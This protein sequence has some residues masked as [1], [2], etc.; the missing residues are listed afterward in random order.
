MYIYIYI[1]I[2]ICAST[3]HVLHEQT[4]LM[5]QYLHP[6]EWF[7]LCSLSV[8]TF[9][10]VFVLVLVV[11]VVV[12]VLLLL[13]LLLLLSILLLLFSMLAVGEVSGE[14]FGEFFQRAT[15]MST[16]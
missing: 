8:F 9:T 5:T 1:Y 14:E 3:Y 10:F 12:V 4:H 16:C 7:V 2:Y 13:L 6:V 11:V 15:A